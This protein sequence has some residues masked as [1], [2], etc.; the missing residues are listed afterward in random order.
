MGKVD[1]VSWPGCKVWFW[2]KDHREPHFHVESPGSWE[3]RVFFGAEPPYYDVLM[4]IGRI[5][6][7]R[8]S[9]FLKEVSEN[10][11]SLFLEWDEKV[12]VVDP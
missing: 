5:P 6:G 7:K 10:R 12:I 8:M 3:V 11:E 4:Q 1:C 2:S 9:A